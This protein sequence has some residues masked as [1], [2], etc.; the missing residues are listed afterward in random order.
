MFC[1]SYF[2]AFMTDRRS[3]ETGSSV[4]GTKN[5]KNIVV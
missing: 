5:E 2:R 1:G 3:E 4:T